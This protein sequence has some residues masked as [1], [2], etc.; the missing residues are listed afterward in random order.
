MKMQTNRSIPGPRLALAVLVLAGL[1]AAARA[2][3]PPPD[4]V[5][6][7]Q[8]AGSVVTYGQLRDVVVAERKKAI[9]EQ[10]LDVFTPTEAADALDELVDVRLLAQSARDRGVDRRPDV[11]SRIDAAVADVLAQAAVEDLIRTADLRSSALKAY[12]ET[13]LEA[14]RT[15][16]RVHLRHIVVRTRAEAEAAEAELRAG[17]EFAAIARARNVDAT[18]DKGG[19]LG[20]IEPAVLSKTF[21][22]AVTPLAAGQTSAIVPSA[23]GFHLLHA[24]AIDAG[25]APPFDQIT[26]QVRRR[27]V[28][29]RI[30]ALTREL[31]GRYPVT[32]HRDLL[33]TLK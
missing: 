30:H 17:G 7:A 4:S 31:R 1:P 3:T 12:Y 13:H 14:F 29:E 32:V 11:A 16:P 21:R 20:W 33:G 24:D 25:A 18:R 28:E 22:E 27:V 23:A 26:E 2:Q 15:D 19:D 9:A 6:V 10:R 8:A 5:P